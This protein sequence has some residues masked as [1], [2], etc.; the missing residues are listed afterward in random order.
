M[1]LSVSTGTCAQTTAPT[2]NTRDQPTNRLVAGVSFSNG[3]S[4]LQKGDVN[5]K[6]DQSSNG[7]TVRECDG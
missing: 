3:G 1:Q 6:L 2:R 4:W 5:M 7:T